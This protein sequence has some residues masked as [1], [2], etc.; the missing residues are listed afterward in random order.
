M[1]DNYVLGPDGELYH[2]GTKGM[3]WGIRRYQN[4]DGSLTPAGK[5]RY[6]AE[7]EKLKAREKAIKGKEKALARQA[8]LDA[9]KA[10]LDAREAALKGGNKKPNSDAEKAVANKPKTMRD[11]TDDEL[12][13]YTNR[14]QLEKKY[15][16]A[17]KELASVMPQKVT[18]GRQFLNTIMDDV[19]TPTI[20][21]AGKDW[22]ESAMKKAAGLNEKKKVDPL[23]KA[24]DAYKKLEWETKLKDLKKAGTMKE[25]KAPSWDDLT[26]QQT[27]IKNQQ[28]TQEAQ[29]K[30]EAWMKERE[31]RR[32][33]GDD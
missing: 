18:K 16:D 23:K 33:Q 21:S 11:M 1:D 3:K 28:S 20:K 5:K 9:K 6:A 7:N 15:L 10:E 32:E 12:R 26:K 13:E 31:K 25:T 4:K 14:M 8:K 27:W 29:D 19:L 24:E 17:Q 2:W 22:L 30:Y